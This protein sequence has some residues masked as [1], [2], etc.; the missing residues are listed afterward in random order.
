MAC[1]D[2]TDCMLMHVAI[3]HY[4][5]N[6]PLQLMARIWMESPE[7]NIIPSYEIAIFILSDHIV[8]NTTLLETKRISYR[9]SPY[10]KLILLFFFM[11]N[12]VQD[13]ALVEDCLRENNYETELAIVEVLQ[14]MSL[15]EDTSTSLASE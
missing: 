1:S 15:A 3:S 9:H 5:P 10:L 11:H 7:I 2:F 14:L 6:Y 13:M 4:A 8:L 12:I